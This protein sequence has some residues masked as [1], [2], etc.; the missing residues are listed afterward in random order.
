MKL[1]VI[2]SHPIQYYAPWFKYL[3]QTEIQLKIFYLWNFGITEQIDPD[4]EKPIKWDIPL[5]EG[6]DYQFITNASKNPGTHSFWGLQN[7]SLTKEV[8]QYNPDAVMLI[9]YN[10]ASLYRFIWQWRKTKIPLIFRGDSHILSPQTGWKKNLKRAFISFIYR[11][12]EAVLYVGQANYEYFRYHHVKDN[13]LFFAPHSVDNQRFIKFADIAKQQAK[14]W[15]QELGI[16]SD[17]RVIVFAGKFN[18]KKC[19]LD[20]LRAYFAA[21]LTNV[22]LLFV[23]S[24]ELESQLKQ[25]AGDCPHIY[26]APF[27]NQALMP[28]TYALADLFVLPSNGNKETWGLAI[29]EAMC[30]SRPIIV[31][32]RVGCAGDLIFPNQNGL[33]FP[34]GN[35]E[36]LAKSLEV[37]FSD[38]QRL[39]QWGQ[40]SYEIVSQYSYAQTTKGLIQA[41][42]YLNINSQ[43]KPE[44]ELVHK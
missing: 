40:K 13:K 35:V 17:N 11:Q 22:S 19:P 20:L 28:R 27:Q 12:F 30:L 25:Q 37:A 18:Q 3:A 29:N 7:P 36:A 5:L 10:Y 32:D 9:G 8:K 24:G 23:G 15:K 14:S 4:F 33:V 6:Y 31:S 34:A 26:F 2:T 44:L 43:N 41:L 1:A 42:N 38:G 21:K 39:K 16:P